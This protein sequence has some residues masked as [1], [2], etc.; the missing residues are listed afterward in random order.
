[1]RG[2]TRGNDSTDL[3]VPL[4]KSLTRLTHLAPQTGVP[5]D[6]EESGASRQYDAVMKYTKGVEG[7]SGAGAG[8]LV[9]LRL[10][11]KPAIQE[12]DIGLMLEGTPR[13]RQLALNLPILPIGLAAPLP[14]LRR[15]DISLGDAHPSNV[16]P[17]DTMGVL[18]DQVEELRIRFS[19]STS[20][21]FLGTGITSYANLRRLHLLC[22]GIHPYNRF[23][24]PPP[25]TGCIVDELLIRISEAPNRYLYIDLRLAQRQSGDT[26]YVDDMLGGVAEFFDVDSLPLLEGAVVTLGMYEDA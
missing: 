26:C 8:T 23:L 14:P 21:S 7:V 6:G 9:D 24:R 17:F 16:S 13:L 20:V 1:M 18:M 12:M 11:I 25:N 4:G 10:E 2:R 5:T 22:Y 19:S 15:L 3:F